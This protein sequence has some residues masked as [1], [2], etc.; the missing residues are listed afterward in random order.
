LQ[1]SAD[2]EDS[3]AARILRH[4]IA[5][6]GRLAPSIAHEVN[7]PLSYVTSNLRHALRMVEELEAGPVA[8]ELGELLHDALEGAE[9]IRRVAEELRRLGRGSVQGMA[10]ADLNEILGTV[11]QLVRA[12]TKDRVAFEL[13]LETLP[14]IRCHRYQ[15]AELLLT[16]LENAVEASGGRGAVR[17]TT[18]AAPPWVEVEITD[19][20]PGVRPD[21]ADRLH[22]PCSSTNGGAAGLG[23]AISREI[24]TVHGGSL[25]AASRGGALFQ[26]RLPAGSS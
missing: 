25:T 5:A 19:G 14:P 22:E 13:R 18:R 26:L 20:G 23:L 4:H 16:L 9:R 3:G 12:E 11:L 2:V 21:G 24:A 15:L 7:D 10:P 6:L 8:S 17:V 1:R